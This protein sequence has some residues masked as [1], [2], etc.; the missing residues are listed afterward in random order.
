MVS[1]AWVVQ[2]VERHLAGWPAAGGPKMVITDV[3][4]HRLGWVI[5]SQ[6]EGYVRSRELI[7]MVVGHGPFLVDG[8]D[9]SLQMVHA[10]A[11]LEASEW[12]EDHRA[13]SDRAG[14]RSREL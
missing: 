2:V 4:P 1:K 3:D 7:D 11:D 12:I 13:L 8:M 5:C 10:T 9:G 14:R 6:S